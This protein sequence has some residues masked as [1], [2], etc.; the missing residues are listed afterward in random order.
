M[1]RRSARTAARFAK[2]AELVQTGNFYDAQQ[3]Y[4]SVFQKLVLQNEIEE[5]TTALR[6]GA[7]LMLQSNQVECGSELSKML[8]QHLVTTKHAQDD[9]T[10]DMLRGIA[11]LFPKEHPLN[12]IDFLRSCIRFARLSFCD[13]LRVDGQ[14][15]SAQ[16]KLATHHCIVLSHSGN[17]MMT[18]Q[19]R[20]DISPER[21]ALTSLLTC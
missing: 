20:T 1:S 16:P 6:T 17:G 10:L 18:R 3:M 19:M 21:A 13:K 5:A 15:L 9:S 12:A 14:A 8:V 2:I 4:K 11:N 7:H